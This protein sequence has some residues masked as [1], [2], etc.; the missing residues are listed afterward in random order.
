VKVSDLAAPTTA[1][2]ARG[3]EA[4]GEVVRDEDGSFQVMLDPEG[5][6]FCLVT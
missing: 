1:C 5:N 3:A 2:V 6:E 4:L